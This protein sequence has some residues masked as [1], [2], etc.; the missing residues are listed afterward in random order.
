M[1]VLVGFCVFAGN[2][3]GERIGIRWFERE[4]SPRWD[5]EIEN[6]RDLNRLQ[7]SRVASFKAPLEFLRVSGAPA[8]R[9][10]LRCRAMQRTSGITGRCAALLLRRVHWQ[11]RY[12]V[13]K[14]NSCFCVGGDQTDRRAGRGSNRRA[15]RSPCIRACSEPARIAGR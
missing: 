9:Q 2:V 3:L 7:G 10:R 8:R 6:A 13:R 1:P 5:E 14:L 11:Y 15:S 4:K 12:A